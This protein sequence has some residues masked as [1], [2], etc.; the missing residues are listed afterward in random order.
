MTGR[1]GIWG[2]LISYPCTTLRRGPV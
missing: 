1:R 2:V